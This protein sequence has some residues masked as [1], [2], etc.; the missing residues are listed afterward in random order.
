V[1]TRER[2]T[3]GLLLQPN[4]SSFFRSSGWLKMIL[5][6]A[7]VGTVFVLFLGYFKKPT[8]TIDRETRSIP[9][10]PRPQLSLRN[11]RVP[12]RISCSTLGTLF[13]L[14]EHNKWVLAPTALSFFVSLLAARRSP[15][16]F[17]ITQVSSDQEE[18]Y[19]AGLI[20]ESGLVQHG[21]DPRKILFCSTSEGRRHMVR[22]LDPLLHIDANPTV[23]Q[24]LQPH[25]SELIWI[26]K[27]SDETNPFISQNSRSSKNSHAIAHNIWMLSTIEELR[28][29]LRGV[30]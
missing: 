13:Q 25:I 17:L 12:L 20:Q 2:N 27:E 3:K 9:D 22:Q 28:P 11:G 23:I 30:S 5:C 6:A 24:E 4:M 21:L 29:S 26:S 8:K 14:N 10:T 15:E 7:G 16:L 18:A 19:F 1:R